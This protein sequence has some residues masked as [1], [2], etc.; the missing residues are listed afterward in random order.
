V[1][2]NKI[3]FGN[4]C[5]FNRL[6][7]LVWSWFSSIR[8]KNIPVSGPITQEK[9]SKF[10]IDLCLTDFKAPNG[11][12]D[13]WK[14]RHSVKGLKVSC[15]SA[16]VNQETVNNYKKRLPSITSGYRSE[17]VFNCDETG[18]FYRT[19]PYRTLAAKGS[20]ATGTNI[21]KDSH[22]MFACRATGEKL[23]PLMIGKSAKSRCLKNVKRDSL[24]VRYV[25]NKKRWMTTAIFTDCVRSINADMKR[26]KRQI[27]LFLD[28][29]SSHGQGLNLSYVTLSFLP[30]I[31]HHIFSSWTRGSLE[32][33]R[34]STG[35]TC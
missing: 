29:A 33:L 30:P 31:R 8:A 26:Q 2:R 17:V 14:S 34:P 4:A 22:L 11:W 21:S 15:E 25:A 9:S 28:N 23:R 3:R 7:D 6:N 19:L 27:I 20:I 18:L 10:A 35:S 24:G 13:S 5:K 1:S 32:R 16:G 12:L